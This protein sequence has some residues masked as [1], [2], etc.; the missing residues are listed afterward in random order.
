MRV[1]LTDTQ[2]QL[3]DAVRAFAKQRI[4]P[5]AAEHDRASRFPREILSGSTRCERRA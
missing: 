4:E 2:R 1:E 5:V 3:R